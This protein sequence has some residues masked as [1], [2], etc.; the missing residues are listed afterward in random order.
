MYDSLVDRPDETG[1]EACRRAHITGLLHVR[2]WRPAL[3]QCGKDLGSSFDELIP[4][5]FMVPGS[6]RDPPFPWCQRTHSPVAADVDK[7]DN[8]G[9]NK[10][11]AV[12]VLHRWEDPIWA[13]GTRCRPPNALP[14]VAEAGDEATGYSG[15]GDADAP[16][17]SMPQEPGEIAPAV[18]QDDTIQAG[19]V[20]EKLTP[21]GTVPVPTVPLFPTMCTTNVPFHTANFCVSDAHNYPLHRTHPPARPSSWT[22]ITPV[23]IKHSAFKSLSAFLCASEKGGP[24]K[25]KDIRPGVQVA[26]VFSTHAAVIAT[27]T[28]YPL[29]DARS[30]FFTYVEKHDLVNRFEQQFINISSDVVISAA[31]YGS[32]NAK[33]T[34]PASE[35]AK[36]EEALSALCKHMQPWHRITVP[37]DEYRQKGCTAL[38]YSA[39][40]A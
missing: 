36:R 24:H 23:D 29:A 8:N 13:L 40:S 22:S 7:I 39:R 16:R 31:L 4:T 11:K 20:I 6:A 38:N 32:P 30:T 2:G 18:T 5:D 12:V 28:L 27:T 9:V 21:E 15:H 25:L 35:F 17:P 34:T 26:A 3:V 33:G 10:G 14:V 19:E 37:G 1:D